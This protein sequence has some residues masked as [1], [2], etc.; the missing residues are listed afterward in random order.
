MMRDQPYVGSQHYSAQNMADGGDLSYLDYYFQQDAASESV[1]A[2]VNPQGSKKRGASAM[3]V[4]APQGLGVVNL[5]N[6]MGAGDQQG[7]KRQNSL[8]ESMDTGG[9]LALHVV[10]SSV[11]FGVPQVQGMVNLGAQWTGGAPS[12]AR[13]SK[14]QRSPSGSIETASGG[15]YEDGGSE[16][17]DESVVLATGT[18]EKGGGRRLWKK[19]RHNEWWDTVSSSG[20]P[21]AD[22]RHHFRMSPYTFQVLCEQLA[23]AV[24]KED[25]ALRA[26]I[27]VQK[28]VAVCVWRLATGEPLRKVADRFA[29]GVS[30]CHKLVLDVCGAIQATV[31]PNV[32]QWSAAAAMATNAA[33]FEALSGIPGIIGAVYTTHV[34]IIAPKHHVINYLNPRATARKSKTCYSITLQASVD[35]DGT[36]TDVYVCPGAMTDAQTLLLWSMNKPKLIGE[37]LG[38]GMRLVGGA[39]YPLTDWMLVPYSHQNLTLTQHEFNKRVAN[40]RAVAVSAFQRLQGRWACLQRRTEVKVDDLSIMLGACCALHNICER[41]GEPFDLQLLQGLELELDDDNM[42]ANDP[43]PSPAA[44]QMRDTIAHNMLHHATVAGAGSFY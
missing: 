24:R 43:V 10:E 26:A 1:P 34:A 36:F 13:G 33:K 3:E 28:R 41:S 29:I 44:G 38:Q 39:G 27:P 16:N 4:E 8:W 6:E 11:G 32:I 21:A 22:F 31:V 20:Y 18:G 25:T 12:E 2:P 37:T 30:T 9:G 42:V 14:R 35:T 7:F 40:A 23:T 17:V 5:W 19:D 15:S